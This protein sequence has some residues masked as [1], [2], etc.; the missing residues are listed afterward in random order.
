M[1]TEQNNQLPFLDVLVSHTTSNHLQTTVYRKPTN[2]DQYI[3]YNSNHPPN[4]KT[5]I[6]STLTRRAKNIYSTN[7]ND[8]IQH[9]KRAFVGL[10]NYPAQIVHRTIAATLSPPA[11]RPK[12]DSDPIKISIPYVGK[13]SHQISR[14]LQ[15]QA[16]IDTI[17][18]SSSSLNNLLHANG[19]KHPTFDNKTPKSLIITK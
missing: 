4:V 15:Q 3:H 8:E 2:T 11:D 14:L 12:P 1:E 16:G 9:L 13:P 5:G 6:I 18:S 19:R 17:F 7:L 10:N